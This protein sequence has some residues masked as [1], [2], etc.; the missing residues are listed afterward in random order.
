[1]FEV[2]DKAG[3]PVNIKDRVLFTRVQDDMFADGET[4]EVEGIVISLVNEVTVQ[5]QPVEGPAVET[6]SSGILVTDS[7]INRV[8]ALASEEEMQK[9]IYDA[10]K[11]YEDEVVSGTNKKKSTSTAAPKKAKSQGTLKL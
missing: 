10:E 7:L 6:L 1:M 5:I 9:L 3:V 4:E 2:K 8:N 11:R